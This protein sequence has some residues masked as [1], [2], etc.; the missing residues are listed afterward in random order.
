V[1]VPGTMHLP[2]GQS[3]TARIASAGVPTER[4]DG[5]APDEV[6]IPVVIDL[7]DQAS[8]AAFQQ[9]SVTVH[10]PT[11]R[12]EDVLSVPVEALQALDR[13]TFGVE[14]VQSDGTTERIPVTPGLFAGGRVEIAGDGIKAG[15]EV[16][17][18][19]V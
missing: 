8:A 18:P 3:I 19:K 11:E 10:I 17:V 12:R 6:V 4:S 13:S 7:D 1:A 5:S 14:V 9:A 16:V 15:Q 2:D